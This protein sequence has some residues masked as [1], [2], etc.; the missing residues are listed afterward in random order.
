MS[1]NQTLYFTLIGAKIRYYRRI[2]HLSQEELAKRVGISLSTLRRIEQGT[3]NQSTPLV[4][5]MDI[6]DGLN[7]DVQEFLVVSDLEKRL[8]G[9]K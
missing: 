5:L 6:A 3:Y 2:S 7:M 1:T 9:W 8:S 4:T